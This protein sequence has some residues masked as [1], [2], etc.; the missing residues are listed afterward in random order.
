VSRTAARRRGPGKGGLLRR[1]VDRRVA[2]VG[3]SHGSYLQWGDPHRS[4]FHRRDARRR[5]CPRRGRHR[6]PIPGRILDMSETDAKT[7]L[8]PSAQVAEEMRARLRTL[9]PDQLIEMCAQLLSTYVVEGVL[10]LSRAADSTDLAGDTAGE[11][12]RKRTRLNSSH[13]AI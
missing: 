7:P 12:D 13:V 10:P 8:D 1:A 5:R 11:E 9:P 2:A 6:L 3:K 4:G